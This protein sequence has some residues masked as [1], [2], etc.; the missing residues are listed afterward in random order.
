MSSGHWEWRPSF[1]MVTLAV[2]GVQL[3]VYNQA[4]AKQSCCSSASVVLEEGQW[5]RVFSA[6]FHHQSKVHLAVDLLSFLWKGY[7]LELSLGSQQL[8][9]VLAKLSLLV[10]VTQMILALFL[11]ELTG[12]PDLYNTCASTF[13]G[14]LVA[15]KVVN[16]HN[17]SFRKLRRGDVEV[18]LPSPALC[19]V[20]LVA[21]HAAYG[22]SVLPLLAGLLVGIIFK[23]SIISCKNQVAARSQFLPS[24][25][26]LIGMLLS[27]RF[28]CV[29]LEPCV[30]FRTVFKLLQIRQLIVAALHTQSTY[31]FTYT[32][33]SLLSLGYQTEKNW[34][35]FRFLIR[36]ASCVVWVNVAHCLLSWL[37]SICPM[38][39]DF[40]GPSPYDACY[41]GLT[42]ALLALKVLRHHDNPDADYDIASFQMSMPH[43]LGLMVE[44]THLCLFTPKSWITGHTAGIMVG[45]LHAHQPRRF[46]S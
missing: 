35:H 8:L 27:A 28:L 15:L 34:G 19:W 10:G 36:F 13:P 32:L 43:W 26:L 5:V 38:E 16:Q 37:M 45:L 24:T 2:A 14:V 17:F 22:E 33:V 1:P 18:E 39:S 44:L 11:A 41:T 4:L 20:E 42:G 21:L 30:S 9:F 3:L 7:I 25:Y 29:S 40:L 31:Q 6:A 23:N 12:S 46:C